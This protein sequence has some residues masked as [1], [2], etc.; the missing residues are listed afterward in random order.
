[1]T[2]A[3]GS[4][5]RSRHDIGCA[6]ST[7]PATQP[8]ASA[9]EDPAAREAPATRVW[10]PSRPW[11]RP[12]RWLVVSGGARTVR[13]A[14]LPSL[15]AT[16]DW[17]ANEIWVRAV[18]VALRGTRALV[19][20]AGRDF[21]LGGYVRVVDLFSG[22]PYGEPIYH[23]HWATCALLA[24]V[25]GRDVVVAG[26]SDGSIM[27]WDLATRARIG[28]PIV[29]LTAPDPELLGS[30]AS[31]LGLYAVT[32]LA[33]VQADSAALLVSGAEDGTLS[34]W[35]LATRA[36]I[37]ARIGAHQGRVSTLTA[38]H[39]DGVTV[40]VSGGKDGKLGI[41]YFDTLSPIQGRAPVVAHDGEV[42]GVAIARVRNS[43]VHVSGGVDGR[44]RFWSLLT[45]SPV[46]GRD[47]HD[48]GVSALASAGV[49]KGPLVVSGGADGSLRVWDVL[50]ELPVGD[51]VDAHEGEVSAITVAELDWELGSVLSAA[52]SLLRPVRGVV[53]TPIRLALC[54]IGAAVCVGAIVAVVLLSAKAPTM[55]LTPSHASGKV[56]VVTPHRTIIALLYLLSFF[57]SAG[58][59]ICIFLDLTRLLQRQR[60]YRSRLERLN[61]RVPLA[62]LRTRFF[63]EPDRSD[64]GVLAELVRSL[65]GRVLQLEERVTQAGFAREQITRELEEQG[66]RVDENASNMQLVA[67]LTQVDRRPVIA[68]AGAA[69]V[70]VGL[71]LGLA[72]TLVWLYS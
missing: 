35:N 56:Q 12:K 50:T 25:D 19:I 40:L 22:V 69:L 61:P 27:T 26:M 71:I 38:T 16:H 54:V 46:G 8:V 6:L 59:V 3:T 32:A 49:P 48:G 15:R 63:A 44:L 23:D 68:L 42:S 51:P 53:S 65:E 33:S 1:M 45:M 13:V 47:A 4:S 30:S 31:H 57:A 29:H 72:A 10:R 60:E 43:D 58:G 39:N 2:T 5:A 67:E 28:E 17:P 52:R 14:E 18:A 55:S 21:S 20:S 7:E 34:L 64:P 37:G 11:R 41:Y 9:G 24:H 70:S 66:R 62:D 36:Q